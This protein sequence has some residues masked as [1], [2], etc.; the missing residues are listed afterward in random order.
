MKEEGIEGGE[1]A[2]DCCQKKI[3]DLIEYSEPTYLKE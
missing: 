3:T 1:G 2:R